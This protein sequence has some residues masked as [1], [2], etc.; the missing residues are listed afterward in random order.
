MNPIVRGVHGFFDEWFIGRRQNFDVWYITLS[1]V[2]QT[3]LRAIEKL[4]TSHKRICAPS[5]KWRRHTNGFARHREIDDV[6]QTALRAIEEMTTSHK[7][8]CAQP[9]KWRRH[10]N[11]FTHHPSKERRH[12]N[13]NTRH[14][15]RDDGTYYQ[16]SY[17]FWFIFFQMNLAINKFDSAFF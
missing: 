15:H 13:K 5:K 10:T 16:N 8:L 6:T 11:W 14:G 2:T 12:S 4:T 1:D 7:Q 9:R 17:L 3:A